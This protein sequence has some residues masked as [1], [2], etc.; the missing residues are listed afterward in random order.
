MEDVDSYKKANMQIGYER[1]SW[2]ATLFV[3]NLTNETANTVTGSGATYAAEYWG[4][5]GFS[6]TQNLARPRTIS[7]RL[8][9]RW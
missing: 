4:H 8:T 5:T 6:D 2:S 1:E 3:G 9:K 7:L